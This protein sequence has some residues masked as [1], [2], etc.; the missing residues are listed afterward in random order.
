MITMGDMVQAEKDKK[1]MEQIE[2]SIAPSRQV[3]ATL[4]APAHR[5]LQRLRLSR[6]F[7]RGL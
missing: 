2:H 5:H 6:L 4:P 3:P 1:E 7:T